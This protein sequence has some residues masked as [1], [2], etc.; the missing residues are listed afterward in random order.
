[1]HYLTGTL[2]LPPPPRHT[3]THTQYPHLQVKKLSLRK[4]KHLSHTAYIPTRDTLQREIHESSEKE[5]GGY[6]APKDLLL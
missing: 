5:E 2:R 6:L 3:R 4:V 1:M